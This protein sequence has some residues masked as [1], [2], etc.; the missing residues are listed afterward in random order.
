MRQCLRSTSSNAA[1]AILVLVF[2][3][4]C[5]ATS[6]QINNLS[7]TT[8]NINWDKFKLKSSAS[9]HQE[10]AKKFP[11]NEVPNI[12]LKKP[13]AAGRLT[14]GFGYRMNPSGVKLPKRHS[15]IDYSA[16][17]GTT[18]FASGAGT[19]IKKYVSTSYGNF[20]QIKH[21]NGFS[22]AYAHLDDYAPGIKEGASV[23][24]G[25]VIGFVGSTGRSTAPH[26]HYELR[27][28]G[29]RID[30]FLGE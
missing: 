25:Q 11:D 30:P 10:I 7:T 4:G 24:K 8:K 18:V 26:L 27:Y 22:S 29:E 16:P 1:I 14:S 20:V 6:E 13:V 2:L 21:A 3:Q 28:K 17:K 23:S 12:L 15:G 19:I 9:K 5:A